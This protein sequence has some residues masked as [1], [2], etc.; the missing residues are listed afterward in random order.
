MDKITF[1]RLSIKEGINEREID[2]LLLYTRTD[3]DIARFTSD[4]ARFSSKEKIKKWL[5]QKERVIYCLVDKEDSLLGIVWFSKKVWRNYNVTFAIRLYGKVRGRGLAYWFMGECF[6]MYSQ[7]FKARKFWLK[8]SLDNI[9]AIKTYKKFGFRKTTKPDKAG[10][11][12]MTM[13]GDFM[14]VN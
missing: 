8:V 14:A 7:K 5:R 10:K 1:G 9:P 12:I 4:T 3:P 11:I 6:K 13:Q 2:W